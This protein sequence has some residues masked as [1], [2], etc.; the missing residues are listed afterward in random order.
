VRHHLVDRRVLQILEPQEHGVVAGVSLIDS[1]VTVVPG[2]G[3]NPT[4]LTRPLQGQ[5]PYTVNANLTWLSTNGG[6]ELGA[7]YGV[8]GQRIEAAGGSGVPDIKE[9]PRHVLDL[10]LRQQITGNLSMKLKAQNLLNS[11]YQ[12]SQESNGIERV[13]RHYT[14]GQSLSVALT[15]GN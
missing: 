14:V 9:D 13:Q 10:T 2:S 7:Y 5:S 12:W 8:F 3:F 15:Y 1:N 6:T 4:N 11:P